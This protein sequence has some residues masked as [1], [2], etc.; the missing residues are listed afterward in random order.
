MKW[1][2]MKKAS[3]KKKKIYEM[4]FYEMTWRR[5]KIEAYKE[6]RYFGAF[7]F[8]SKVIKAFLNYFIIN[9]PLMR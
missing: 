5:R 6:N 3:K 4:A 1:L 8:Y 9:L 7:V 2:S